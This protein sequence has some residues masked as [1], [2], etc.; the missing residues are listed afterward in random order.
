MLKTKRDERLNITISETLKRQFD[1][2]C[3]IK[4]MSMSDAAQQ[5][6]GNWIKQNLTDE[7]LKAIEN[8]PDKEQPPAPMAKTEGKTRKARRVNL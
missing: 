7:L 2:V 5:A 6:I 8:L 1:V 4:G 3:A